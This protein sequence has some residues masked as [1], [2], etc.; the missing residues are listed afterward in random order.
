MPLF[1][2]LRLPFND[3]RLYHW[4]ICERILFRIE[5]NF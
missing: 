4:D 1:D 2:Y 5:K 3:N